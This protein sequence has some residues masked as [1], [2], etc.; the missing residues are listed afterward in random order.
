MDNVINVSDTMM[1]AGLLNYK[2][3][4]SKYNTIF[5]L[6]AD[7]AINMMDI[8]ILAKNFNKVGDQYLFEATPA[9]T[10]ANDYCVKLTYETITKDY[11]Y[12][13]SA[14]FE[15]I[16]QYGPGEV[17]YYIIVF[18]GPIYD[19]MKI[20]AEK[21]GA[22]LYSYIY[23]Y[24]FLAAIKTEDVEKVKRLPCVLDVIV[25][26]NEY[27]VIDRKILGDYSGEVIVGFF[28]T[29]DG[30]YDFAQKI[31][32]VVVKDVWGSGSSQGALLPLGRICFII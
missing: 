4:D 26:Q 22:K 15:K 17:G 1:I 7:G 30:I 25:F 5:D 20:D 23:Q 12:T 19:S 21:V 32:S 2:N 28:D 3:G 31:G 13:P 16:E 8:V 6:N 27:K 14:G 18:S 29:S 24:S 9:P 10:P 11:V